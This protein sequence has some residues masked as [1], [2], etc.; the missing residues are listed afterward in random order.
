MKI[1]ISPC[2]N[3]IFIFGAWILGKIDW[4]GPEPEFSFH[5]ISE[6]NLKATSQAKL[7]VVKISFALLPNI[8]ES[9]KL[10]R[11]GSALGKG[12]GP[13]LI[14]Y[15]GRP[16]H[17]RKEIWVP[18]K[19]TTAFL[20]CQKYSQW[21]GAYKEMRYDEI[22]PGL[23]NDSNLAGVIIHESRF[24]YQDSG[25]ELLLDL[26]QEWENNTSCP[27]PLGGIVMHRKLNKTL[28][29]KIE[30]TIRRSLEYAKQ[31]PDE[32]MSLMKQ[33][34]QELD[35]QVILN[36]VNLYVNQYSEDLGEDGVN[37]IETLCGIQLNF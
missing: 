25:L 11:S 4:D 7:D 1:A 20:L 12:V 36:H 9:Y 18:G 31:H 13:L 6:L 26:G 19:L 16:L 35:E 29:L 17:T 23:R 2:P 34:A 8:L 30:N 15:S 14:G 3:D 24:T 37:A 33:H 27:L 10:S 28:H 21:D 32:I 5:D 22:I